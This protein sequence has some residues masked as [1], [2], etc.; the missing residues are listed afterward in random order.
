[1]KSILQLENITKYVPGSEKR[2]LFEGV[3]AAVEEAET[4]AILGASGQGKSTLLRILSLLDSPDGGNLYLHEKPSAKWQAVE[5]RRKVCYVAQQPSMLEGSVEDN[6]RIV[7]KLRKQPFD[8]RQAQRLLDK[9]GLGGLDTAKKASGLSG[10]EKQRISLVRAL[11]LKPE[12]MLLD[13]IT[14]ALDSANKRLAEELLQ[15]WHEESGT[16]M[17]WVTHDPQQAE[18]MTGRVWFLAQHR[19][20]EN[21][22]TRSFMANPASPSARE[23]LQHSAGEAAESCH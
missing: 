16:T 5:W 14:S 7:S 9:L 21:T 6:L 1:L 4:I 2:C 22:D 23:Y 11:L 17:I 20:L 18:R 10:G 15:Q 12:I 19:L 3:S 8:E 13:E